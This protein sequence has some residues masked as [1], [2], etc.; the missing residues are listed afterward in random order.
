MSDESL[1]FSMQGL[2][3]GQGRPR[4]T[5]RGGFATVY[6]DPKSRAYEKS[7]GA[8]AALAMGSR[9]PFAGPLSV[10]LRFRMPIPKSETKRVREAMAAGE[11]APTTKPDLSNLVKAIEDGM[12]AVVYVDDVQI[13]RSFTTKIYSEKPGVDVQVLPLGEPA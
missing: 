4:A 8:V 5:A 2:P 10:S 6:K 9:T 3:R 12:N 11:I 13:V 1:T 7:V